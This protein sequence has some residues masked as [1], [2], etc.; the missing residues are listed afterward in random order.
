[1]I[2]GT[3]QDEEFVRY[4]VVLSKTNKNV[5][6]RLSENEGSVN[7]HLERLPIKF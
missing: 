3:C 7:T 1:M 5:N 6:F 4:S 2:S